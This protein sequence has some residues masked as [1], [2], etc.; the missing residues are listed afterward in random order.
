MVLSCAQHHSVSIPERIHL[1]TVKLSPSS[2]NASPTLSAN[3]PRPS[4]SPSLKMAPVKS[5]KS[6]TAAFQLEV[7][8][9][10]KE[11][12]NRAA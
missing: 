2:P 3:C 7:I 4:A 6:Y 10:A 9:F 8:Q 12:D 5:R 1:V 11:H